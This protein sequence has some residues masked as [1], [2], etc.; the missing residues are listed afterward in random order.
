MINERFISEGIRIDG[1]IAIGGVAK[2]NPFV[3]QIVA[4]VLNMPIKVATS[5]QTCALGSAMAA[6]VMAGVHKDMDAAQA[7]MGGGFEKEY[8]PDKTRAEKYNVLFRKYMELGKFVEK[9]KL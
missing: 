9:E 8:Q 7:A 6:A 3:M 5:E 2:K 4:D 1:V